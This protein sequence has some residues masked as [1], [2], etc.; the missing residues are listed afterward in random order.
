MVNIK[1]VAKFANVSTA[2]VSRIINGRP[3]ANVETEKRVNEA[4]KKLNYHP[5]NIARS[6]SNKSSNL[7]AF[8][9]PNLNNP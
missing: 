7:I 2:T 1:D 4:I 6:L 8:I 5:S 9:V 3:G